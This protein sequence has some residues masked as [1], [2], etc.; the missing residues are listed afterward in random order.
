MQ[1][2]VGISHLR[3]CRTSSPS[4]SDHEWL[5]LIASLSQHDQHTVKWKVSR[6]L[7]RDLRMR[8]QI[9][10]RLNL[11][12]FL[13]K[14]IFQYN[15]LKQLCKLLQS[16]VAFSKIPKLSPADERQMMF[17]WPKTT[18]KPPRHRPAMNGS[19]CNIGVIDYSQKVANMRKISLLRSL[20]A[21]LKLAVDLFKKCAC[22]TR[23]TFC[24]LVTLNTVMLEEQRW[25]IHNSNF[26]LCV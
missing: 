18:K 6:G 11:G 20:W 16:E 2:N 24:F 15:Q 17:R 5:Q 9:Y 13:E 10:T 22:Q 12:V 7:R 25:A 14:C 21:W 1:L 4:F 26:Q 3:Y 23:Q 19:C 8:S